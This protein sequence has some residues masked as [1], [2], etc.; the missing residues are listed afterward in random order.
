MENK[1]VARRKRKPK[2]RMRRDRAY[3]ARKNAPG[4]RPPGPE[5]LEQ[6][7]AGQP[8]AG[9]EAQEP[10]YRFITVEQRDPDGNPM[11]SREILESTYPRRYAEVP[12]GTELKAH[13][14]AG[15]KPKPVMMVE[16]K[17]YE[18]QRL[19]VQGWR[20]SGL[21]SVEVDGWRAHEADWFNAMGRVKLTISDPGRP[22]PH[23]EKTEYFIADS[24]FDQKMVTLVDH[25]G[26]STENRLHEGTLNITE[27]WKS[28]WRRQGA[29]VLNL[30]FKLLLAPL[31]VGLGVGGT[32]WWVD[33]PSSPDADARQTTAAQSAAPPVQTQEGTPDDP[34]AMGNK[35][36][37][38]AL[39][40]EETPQPLT[41][42]QASGQDTER[43]IQ[44]DKPVDEAGRAAEP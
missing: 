40:A 37:D 39:D 7:E 14:L 20:R 21:I 25:A 6:A 44:R 17:I 1:D 13:V 33:R 8:S 5:T 18:I 3:R 2:Q 35:G 27:T 29:E 41:G 19:S 24:S 38:E 30:G 22:G 15:Y 23:N 43:D 32:L 12:P 10:Q 4:Q 9:H 11:L 26:T 34:A 16:R 36:P 42:D 31:L 28:A